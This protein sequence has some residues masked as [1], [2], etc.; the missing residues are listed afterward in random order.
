MENAK[1]LIITFISNILFGI[2]SL[3]GINGAIY[4][5]FKDPNSASVPNILAW[6]IIIGLFLVFIAVNYFCNKYCRTH[7]TVGVSM[8]L[9]N[10]L[11]MLFGLVIP[12]IVYFIFIAKR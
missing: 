5:S 1:I 11:V 12:Y 7:K 10:V 3:F 2:V 4:I 8:Y 6:I 9:L